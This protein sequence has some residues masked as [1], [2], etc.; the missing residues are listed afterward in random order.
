M[1][2]FD[3]A[4]SVRQQAAIAIGRIGDKASISRLAKIAKDY[5]EVITRRSI[6]KSIKKLR[7]QNKLIATF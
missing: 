5:P 7:K 6:M 4:P 2:N 1:T 3:N